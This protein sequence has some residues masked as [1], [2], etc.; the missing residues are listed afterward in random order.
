VIVGVGAAVGRAAPAGLEQP[1]INNTSRAKEKRK[2]CI[3]NASRK[4]AKPQRRAKF[5]NLLGFLGV[6]AAL[7]EISSLTIPSTTTF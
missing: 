2:W 6:F 4:G 5:L 7:R 3:K 1:E